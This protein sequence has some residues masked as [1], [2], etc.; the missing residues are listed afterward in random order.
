MQQ[1]LEKNLEKRR[2]RINALDE[3]TR[4]RINEL[5]AKGKSLSDQLMETYEELQKLEPE[6]T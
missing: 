6:I 3:A 4:N 2:A 1:K 5:E